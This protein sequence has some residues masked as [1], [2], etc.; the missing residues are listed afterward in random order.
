[1]ADFER[2][3]RLERARS[4]HTVRAYV[5]DVSALERFLHDH[6]G[7]CLAEATLTDLRSWLGVIAAGGAARTTIARRSASVRAF[8][9]WAVHTGRLESDPST[10]LSA[11]A[12]HRPLPAVL[13]QEQAREVLA[14]AAV[15]SDDDD[16]V[17]VRNAALLEVL[18]ATGIRVGELVGLDVD[19]ADLDG[20]TVRVLGKGNKERIV[21]FG[22]PAAQAL[23]RWLRVGRPALVTATS[24]PALWLGRRGGRLDQRQARSAV[25]AALSLVPDAPDIGPHG[26][27]HSA[28]THLVEGGADLRVVQELLGHRSLATTQ[29]Y[30]HVS[31]ERLRSSYRQAHPRA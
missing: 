1:M 29:L 6:A 9:R 11:P 18:Y 8:Y 13:A 23:L 26:W 3:L 2:H 22:A 4:E 17:A 21:P 14:A 15:A 19:D 16:P 10:R 27:R 7:V 5:A 31:V 24:G 25:H 30:T 20:C 28:A 12:K